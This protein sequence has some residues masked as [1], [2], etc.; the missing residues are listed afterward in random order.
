M[1]NYLVYRT[2]LKPVGKGKLPDIQHFYIREGLPHISYTTDIEDA[3][4]MDKDEAEYIA[5]LT[6]NKVMEGIG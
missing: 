5:Y 4:R 3:E 6:E 1:T 2:Q